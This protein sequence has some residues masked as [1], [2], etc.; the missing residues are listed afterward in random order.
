MDLNDTLGQIGLIYRLFHPKAEYMFFSRSHGTFSRIYHILGHKTSLNKFK[1]TEI[2]ST[3][4]SSHNDIKLEI[5]HKEK[6][7]K[8]PQNMRLINMP[9]NNQ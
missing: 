7:E 2:I 4:F 8:T 3:I 9:L 5:N 6:M 1:K